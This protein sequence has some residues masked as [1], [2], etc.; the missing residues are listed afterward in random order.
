MNKTAKEAM[1]VAYDQYKGYVV[2]GPFSY[3]AA[4][5]ISG[6]AMTVF[7]ALG[8]FVTGGFMNTLLNF[9]QVSR[10]CYFKLIMTYC[11]TFTPC[12]C[13]VCEV[14]LWYSYSRPGEPQASARR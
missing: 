4:C 10:R 8:I 14:V 11:A 12:S 2:D 6:V 13:P 7:G 3:K 9:Y 5:F 1:A